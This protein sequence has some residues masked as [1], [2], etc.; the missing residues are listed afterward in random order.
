[1]KPL[2]S[3]E[4]AALFPGDASRQLACASLGL[5]RRAERLKS[6][7]QV[8][9]VTLAEAVL[10]AADTLAEKAAQAEPR[11]APKKKDELAL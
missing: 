4:T 7:P 11:A 1:M 5:L 10:G 2:L 3:T 6:W 8:Y 9:A